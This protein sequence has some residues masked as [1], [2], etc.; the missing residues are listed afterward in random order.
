[1]QLRALPGPKYLTEWIKA[2]RNEFWRRFAVHRF[3]AD[4]AAGAIVAYDSQARDVPSTYWQSDVDF[5]PQRGD[6]YCRHDGRLPLRR[7]LCFHAAADVPAL[8][9]ERAARGL[10]DVKAAV[11]EALAEYADDLAG[12]RLTDQVEMLA[13]LLPY[14]H[15]TVRSYLY[16]LSKPAAP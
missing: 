2:Q 12:L 5:D 13:E 9:A 1:M 8:A 10:G 4:A 14:P 16:R 3:L 15:S 11:I 7:S 6:L